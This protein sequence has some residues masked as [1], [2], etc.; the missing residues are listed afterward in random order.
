MG[1]FLLFGL[2]TT[3]IWICSEIQSDFRPKNQRAKFATIKIVKSA[4]LAVFAL[5]D[6]V[7]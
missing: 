2:V 5:K 3:E 7:W 1:D 6:A 4:D